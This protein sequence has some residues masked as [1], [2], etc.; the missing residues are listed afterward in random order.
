[1]KKY[2]LTGIIGILLIGIGC[3]LLPFEIMS[4]D[5]K[6]DVNPNLEKK[7]ITK[8]YNIY[9]NQIYKI[10]SEPEITKII[11]DNTL[12]DKIEITITYPESYFEIYTTEIPDVDIYQIFYEFNLNFD[13]KLLKETFSLFIEDIASKQFYNYNETFA[14]TVVIRV[15]N[16]N[17]EN[18]K[19]YNNDY[20]NK[21]EGYDFND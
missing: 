10:H 5:Y 9:T 3:G 8:E 12:Q 1:M 7:T 4:F 13:T 17:L 19:I 16:K 11:T 15:S 21:E 14:P 18:V 20:D 2:L 6:D